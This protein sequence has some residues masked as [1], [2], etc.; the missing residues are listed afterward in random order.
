MRGN[1]VRR[2]D[3]AG[4]HI[5]KELGRVGRVCPR[6][7]GI[8]D[9]TAASKITRQI[10]LRRNYRINRCALARTATFVIHKEEEAIFLNRPSQR[11]AELVA[12]Q[13]RNVWGEKVA[14]LNF[15]VP[16]KFISTAVK[17]VA[18]AFERCV[19]DRRLC[20]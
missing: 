14:G 12:L 6:R 3:V 17:C 8:V 1:A 13:W 9:G 16:Q 7:K 10:R 20:T 2:D 18:A 4:E 11:A 15:L 19:N 5:A